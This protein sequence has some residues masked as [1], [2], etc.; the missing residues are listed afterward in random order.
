M[1]VI[2]LAYHDVFENVPP[3]NNHLRPLAVHYALDRVRFRSHLR[4]I[5]ER[6]AAP[7]AGTLARFPHPQ[8]SIPI[9]LTFD[10]GASESYRCA[11]DELESLNWRGHFFIVSDWIGKPGFMNRDQIRDLH[12]RGHAIGSHSRSHPERMNKLSRAQLR[13]EWETSC[14][15][16]ADVLGE[17]TR[18][19]SVPNGFYSTAIAQT[20]ASAGIEVLFN[21]EPTTHVHVENGC[22]VLGRFAIK[23]NSPP[24]LSGA[25]VAHPIPRLRQAILWSA[26]KV[27]KG[28]AFPIYKAFRRHALL[29]N[30][31]TSPIAPGSIQ[32]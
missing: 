16:L 4:S 10:D 18:I 13:M 23:S 8:S 9:L 22:A 24:E 6:C 27:A 28:T 31:S 32:Q 2:A 7:F 5:A 30:S 3:Q 21:S 12:Q 25:L 17:Q 26:I 11:A 19:A 20:A 1:K 29:R 15:V 14:A